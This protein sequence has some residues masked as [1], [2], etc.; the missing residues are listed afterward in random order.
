MRGPVGA[1]RY[2]LIEVAWVLIRGLHVFL[3]VA[4]PTTG[5]KYTARWLRFFHQ[6]LG[7]F[8]KV[9]NYTVSLLGRLAVPLGDFS[10]ARWGSYTGESRAI[11]GRSR[12]APRGASEQPYPGGG[13]DGSRSTGTRDEHYNLISVLYHALQGAD[14]CDRYAL[15]AEA[16]GDERSAGFYRE[17]RMINVQ[18][19]ERAKGMLGIIEPPLEYGTSRGTEGVEPGDARQPGGSG[20]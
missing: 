19:A 2:T 11:H 20:L 8:S 15:D 13:S 17:A 16:S 9:L 4:D 14:S 5:A 6:A 7:F 3:L 10:L 12:T 1:T 18:I